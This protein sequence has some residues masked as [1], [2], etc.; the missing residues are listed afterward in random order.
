MLHGFVEFSDKVEADLTK[1]QLD[2]LGESDEEMRADLKKADPWGYSR[3]IRAV[4]DALDQHLPPDLATDP[5][6]TDVTMNCFDRLMAIRAKFLLV[7]M[8]KLCRMSVETLS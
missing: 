8:G 1:Q 2:L 5:T 6:L 4:H 3:T 7:S